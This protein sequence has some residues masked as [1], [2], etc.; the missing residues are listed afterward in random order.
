MKWDVVRPENDF[1]TLRRLLATAFP[2]YV[3]PLLPSKIEYKFTQKSLDKRMKQFSRF[4]NA[5][6]RN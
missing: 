1:Y 2:H 5:V 6:C 3:V 4:L